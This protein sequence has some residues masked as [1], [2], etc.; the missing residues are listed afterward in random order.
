MDPGASNLQ[1]ARQVTPAQALMLAEQH[2]EAGRLTEAE[3]VCRQIVEAQGDHAGAHHLLGLLSWR[4]GKPDLAIQLIEQAIAFDGAQAPFHRNIAEM[5]RQTGR[6][7]DALTSAR[8]AVALDASDAGAHYNLGVVLNELGEHEEGMR[9]YQRAV[10]ADPNHGLAYNNLGSAR[11]RAG[12]KAGAKEAY[13]RAVDIDANHTEAQ[14]NLGAILSEEG[15]L[16]GARACFNAAI[17]AR[18]G[19]IDPHFNLSTLKTYEPGDAQ[20]HL[21]EGLVGDVAALAPA[22]QARY[23]F[24]V[25]KARADLGDRARAFAAYREGNRLARAQIDYDEA[26]AERTAVAVTEV[27]SKDFFDARS[28][29]ISRAGA[30]ETPVFI[31]GMP[32][33]GTTLVEQI[34]A[35]HPAVYGAGELHD[36]SEVVRT[37]M[38]RA[39][40]TYPGGLVGLNAAGFAD[41]GADYLAKL[42]AQDPR[43]QRITDKMPAN[44]FYVGLI[45]LI[46]PGAR[47]VHVRRDAMDTCWSNYTRHFKQTMEFAYE[48]E[49]LGRYHNRYR[50]L[51][52]HWHEVLPEAAILDIDYEAVIEDLEGQARRLVDHIGLDWHP[53]CLAFHE[54]KRHVATASIA[55][56]RQP[57]YQSSV[58]RWRAYEAELA[59][60]RAALGETDE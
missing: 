1:T 41:M 13:Q 40:G 4:V 48:L 55:Q 52:A 39:G 58:G 7:Q 24:A 43:A 27:L 60:L 21:L 50:R 25:G 14:N 47:I 20:A 6:P 3:T 44:F 33:A 51:M 28:V 22:S 16:D 2:M 38:Q 5:Y 42:R 35:S 8:R 10:A 17:E 49:E 32:R 56:V 57:I 34:L 46:L 23:W 11:E 30:D 36:M 54:N 37:A 31:V 59:P 18:P 19:F 53:S 45:H 26:R 9:A 15:D 29:Q 12:D